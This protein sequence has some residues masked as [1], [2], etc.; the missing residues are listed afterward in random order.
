MQVV[1]KRLRFAQKFGAEYYAVRNG[2]IPHGASY[3]FGIADGHGRPYHDE[4]RL[5]PAGA[6][7]AV[8]IAEHRLDGGAI[9]EI[10]LRIVIR[11]HGDNDDVRRGI[12]LPAVRNGAEGQRARTRP[13]L[14]KEFFNV[15][16]MY[17]RNERIELVYLFL[18]NVHDSDGVLCR[19]QHGKRKPDVAHAGYGY[20][21][22]EG[23]GV[24][25]DHADTSLDLVDLAQ[26]IL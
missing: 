20:T 10:E 8:N 21:A 17:R 25:R 3:L 4:R 16:V 24:Y 22:G 18:Y 6:Y 12:S 14:G 5:A 19:K 2:G 26:S 13:C 11:R 1:V 7:G 23:F 15:I 9:E